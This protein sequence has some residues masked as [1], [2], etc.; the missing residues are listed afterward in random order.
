MTL[1]ENPFRVER[2][3]KQPFSCL[4][5]ARRGSYR[6]ICRIDEDARAVDIVHIDHRT[7]VYRS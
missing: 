3:L 6:V 7:G 5:A 4:Y 2:A 1:A